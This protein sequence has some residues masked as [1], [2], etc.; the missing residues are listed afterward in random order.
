MIAV[1]S[2]FKRSRLTSL[3]ALAV[4]LIAAACTS[5]DDGAETG[6]P[7]VTVESAGASNTVSPVGGSQISEATDSIEMDPVVEEAYE[8]FADTWLR[9]VD[10]SDDSA[11]GDLVPL[12]TAEVVQFFEDWRQT[13]ANQVTERDV[14]GTVSKSASIGLR[15]VE[16]SDGVVLVEDCMRMVDEITIGV[17]TIRYLWQQTTLEEA[18]NGDWIV[19]GFDV[20]H[21]GEP[22]LRLTCV[23]GANEDFLVELVGD[24]ALAS[25][26][27][28]RDPSVG[29]GPVGIED[30]VA[31][32]LANE[33]RAELNQ[34]VA[35]GE[36]WEQDETY[37]ITVL[38]TDP[39]T[40]TPVA[41]VEI[42]TTYPEGLTLW[43]EADTK[44]PIPAELTRR[45]QGRH[46]LEIELDSENYD[47][48]SAVREYKLGANCGS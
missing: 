4:V 38:G 29:I 16:S 34:A 7:V 18:Q 30:L 13:N 23:S 2:P 36:R 48:I 19:T 31:D 9:Y 26:E 8:L 1:G 37:E 6:R 43:S 40:I 3:L 22:S 21:T 32:G 25:A 28:R 5:G 45:V 39:A 15:S 11:A 47:L 14:R 27:A 24:Y 10:D 42:C 12:A 44:L 20:L 17:E 46:V 41:L 33:W 35:N